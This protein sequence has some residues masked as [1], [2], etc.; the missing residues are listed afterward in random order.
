VLAA[1]GLGHGVSPNVAG[2]RAYYGGLKIRTTID[3][4]L[5]EEADRVIASDLPYTPGG[6]A[7]SLVAIDNKTGEVRAMV[8]GPVV[9][10]QE[11]YQ[12][13]PFNLATEGHRQPGSSFKPFTLAVALESGFGPTS[14]FTSAPGDYIVPHSGGK[15]HFIVHNFGNAYSGTISLASATAVS[16]NSVYATSVRT[17]RAESPPWPGRWGSALPSPPT[18]R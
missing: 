17:A 1:M 18:T 5:Q 14:L 8:G 15:E 7:V 12:K 3:L 11:D 9:G 6:P 10:G 2:Y 4:S 13:Y 16:D